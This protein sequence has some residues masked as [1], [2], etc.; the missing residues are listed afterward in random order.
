M[1]G[2]LPL[3]T[4]SLLLRG[5][6]L[7]DAEAAFELSREPCFMR[8]LPSQVYESPE[9]ARSVLEGLVWPGGEPPDPRTAPCVLTVL[10]RND[11]LMVGHVGFSPLRGGVEAG[12]SMAARLQG[13][14]LGS[15]A[16]SA[17]TSWILRRFALECVSAF[18]E[19]ANEAARRTLARAGYLPAGER[20]MHFQGHLR[21]VARFVH[22]A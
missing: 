9:E 11:G 21:L 20:R 1:N 8:W 22:P 18:T 17:A 14:G 7:S 6:A 15:E 2:E 10:C 4:T 3:V 16:L 12:F 19:A 13:E 5:P